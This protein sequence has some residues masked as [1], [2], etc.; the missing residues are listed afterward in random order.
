M[1]HCAVRNSAE[2]GGEKILLEEEK[3]IKTS[4]DFLKKMVEHFLYL[5]Y[6]YKYYNFKDIESPKSLGK[7]FLLMCNCRNNI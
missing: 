4:N 2:F 6:W 7:G 3:W 1:T 5:V